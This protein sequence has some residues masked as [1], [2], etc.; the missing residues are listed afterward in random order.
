MLVS[1]ST[2]PFSSVSPF[3]MAPMRELAAFRAQGKRPAEPSQSEAR[4]K[5]RFDTTLFSS[6]EDYQRYKEK[7]A[8]RKVVPGRNINFSQLQ[9]FELEGLFSRMGWL[10]MV[11][12]SEP[13]FLTLVRAFYSRATNGIGGQIIS[14][15]RGVEIRL[16]SESIYCIFNIAPVGFR[17]YESNIWLTVPGFEPREA[18]Q[19]IFGLADI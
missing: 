10:P 2:S 7:F 16:D 13:I 5:A 19:R 11:T 18:I 12:I 15:V 6:M 8:M 9:H 14:T 4:R 1:L 3:L 17:V